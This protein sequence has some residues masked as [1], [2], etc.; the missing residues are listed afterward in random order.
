MHPCLNTRISSCRWTTK[1][2][3]ALPA[4]TWT[5]DWTF[6]RVIS[7]LTVSLSFD[8]SLTV[9]FPR[10]VSASRGV[11]L[12]S[13][14][15]DLRSISAISA[16]STSTNRATHLT[17]LAVI[18]D[19]EA[20]Y[21]ISAVA[22]TSSCPLA[23]AGHLSLTASL[24]FRWSTARGCYRMSS[25][26]F[27]VLPARGVQLSISVWFLPIVSANEQTATSMRNCGF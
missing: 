22:R 4:K 20:L 10:R 19:N 8:G 26:G 11:H 24:R 16:R 2:C 13:V 27:H 17:D 25:D 6:A 18:M 14:V 3:S 15:C 21:S 1:S 7:L 23:R 12:S 5:N 9:G